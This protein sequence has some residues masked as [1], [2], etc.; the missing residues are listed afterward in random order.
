MSEAW[1]TGAA[2]DL[3]DLDGASPIVATAA[4]T[5]AVSPLADITHSVNLRVKTLAPVSDS[6]TGSSGSGS[7]GK[8]FP[9]APSPV[10]RDAKTRTTGAISPLAS[11]LGK[12]ASPDPQPP[13]P[14]PPGLL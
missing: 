13:P 8:P 3:L 9:F 6:D 4:P 7:G 2:D 11:S 1:L 10:T 5:L 14:P 12:R